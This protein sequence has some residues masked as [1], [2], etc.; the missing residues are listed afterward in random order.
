MAFGSNFGRASKRISGDKLKY[1][2][3]PVTKA[4]AEQKVQETPDDGFNY[5]RRDSMFVSRET[6]DEEMSE[7]EQLANELEV[8]KKRRGSIFGNNIGT[9]FGN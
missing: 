2:S 1:Q 6:E 3:N 7:D 9:M 8:I 5:N 4:A